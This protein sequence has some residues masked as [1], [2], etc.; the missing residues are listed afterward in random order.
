ML[1]GDKVILRPMR[2]D[3]ITHQ[4]EFDQ[5]LELL[6]TA[7]QAEPSGD[8]ERM[9][10]PLPLTA[11]LTVNSRD[12]EG[13]KCE[14]FNRCFYEHAKR[15]AVSA[16]LVVT[17]GGTG[18]SPR[19]LTPEA[20]RRVLDREAPGLAEA[21]RAATFG[22]NPHGMLSR[23]VAGIAGTALVVANSMVKHTLTNEYNERREACE[24]A[25]RVLH[26]AFNLAGPA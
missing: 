12:C 17:T 15:E 1:K 6:E 13:Q 25:V 5:D 10:L 20:T 18:F 4:H 11:R 3:D 24:E 9:G 7:L 22:V 19:D 8:C 16:D 2:P 23:G 26:A 21:L 14:R